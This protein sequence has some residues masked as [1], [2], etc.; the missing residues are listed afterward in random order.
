MYFLIYVPAKCSNNHLPTPIIY[1]SLKFAI[2]YAPV[3]NLP[4]S[5]YS[6]FGVS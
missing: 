2:N 4:H 1:T 3:I 5:P 6:V